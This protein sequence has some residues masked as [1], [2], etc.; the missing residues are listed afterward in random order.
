MIPLRRFME[1]RQMPPKPA[2][3]DPWWQIVLR[4][5]ATFALI[6]GALWWIAT[7][8]VE[9]FIR[10][11]VEDRMTRIEN[12]LDQIQKQLEVITKKLDQK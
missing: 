2:P 4:H 7:P 3:R 11:T 10:D 9:A 6:M 5:G 1:Y 8:R 12:Q